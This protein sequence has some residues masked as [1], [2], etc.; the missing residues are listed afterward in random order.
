MMALFPAFSSS[1]IQ[2][3]F[4]SNARSRSRRLKCGKSNPGLGREG[5]NFHE[6]QLISFIQSEKMSK[7]LA[8]SE[9]S[10]IG[11]WTWPFSTMQHFLPVYVVLQRREEKLSFNVHN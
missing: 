3:Q 1:K 6:V 9:I 5:V 10:S 11:V 4:N 7:N 8:C 2:R